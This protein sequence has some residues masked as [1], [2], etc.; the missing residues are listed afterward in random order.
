MILRRIVEHVKNQHWT[1]I[2]ID[3]VIVVVGV[4]IG[5]QAQ[6]WAVE[7]GRQKNEHEYLDR[8]HSEVEKLIETR[9]IYDRTRTKFSRALINAVDHLNS[10]DTDQVL[11]LEHCDAIVGSAHTTVPPAELPT[12]IEL[13]STGRLDQLTSTPVR[14]A[15]LNY[16]QDAARARDLTTAISRSGHDLGRAFPRLITH[17]LGP[18]RL[19][20]D[21]LW[22]NPECD[23]RAMRADRVFRNEVSENAYMYSVYTERAVLPVSRQL[24][25]LHDVLDA[26]IGIHHSPEKAPI[27]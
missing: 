5:L 17:H 20:V 14:T 19:G 15:I 13:L 23:T 7:R 12:V 6:D 11:S 22:L 3:F 16:M 1:A 21:S 26:E 27:P 8:L 25:A 4:F 24:S 2:V 9:S 18:S 10:S